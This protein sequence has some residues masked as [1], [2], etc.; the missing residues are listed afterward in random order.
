MAASVRIE[1][2]AFSDERFV[3]LGRLILPGS[4]MEIASAIGIGIMSKLWRACTAAG[5]YQLPAALIAVHVDPI[6]VESAMLGEWV[7]G[8]E[9]GQIMRI[10]GTRGRI[11]WLAKR[12]KD[13]KKAGKARAKSGQ[14]VAGRFTSASPAT[15][16]TASPAETSPPAPAPAP[17]PALSL[18]L[19]P[20]V[21]P[22][23]GTGS[24][25]KAKR[26]MI[27]PAHR[28][29]AEQ[30]WDLQE[31]LRQESIPGA[32]RL[33]PSDERLAR[34]ADRLSAGATTE[35]CEHVL[36]VYAS[37]CPEQAKWFNGDTNWRAA[38]FDRALGQ[39]L[40][41]VQDATRRSQSRSFGGGGTLVTGGQLRALAADLRAR[42]E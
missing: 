37:Q 19:T 5:E 30:L 23:G 10:R 33:R 1:D 41:N 32:R 3:I 34:V 25:R 8:A 26:A 14:R 28:I 17:A 12:R 16:G 40:D 31:R 27:H 29:Q 36:R 4:T 35:D 22:H 38:N 2:E 42:G 24:S 13:A 6:F 7:A 39:T 15:A 11:E 20:P 9:N 18:S 21:V